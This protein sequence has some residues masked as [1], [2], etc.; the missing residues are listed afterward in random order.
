V[1]ASTAVSLGS[2]ARDGQARMSPKRLSSHLSSCQ[3][4]FVGQTPSANISS[5]DVTSCIRLLVSKRLDGFVLR[6]G[7]L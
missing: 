1:K 5:S 6:M 3:S 2:L 7:A 4:P